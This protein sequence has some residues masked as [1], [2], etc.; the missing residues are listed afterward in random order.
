MVNVK[1]GVVRGR[2]YETDAGYRIIDM[3]VSPAHKLVRCHMEF[4]S[5]PV[6]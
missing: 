6:R 4:Q 3:P 5:L 1:C 2:S